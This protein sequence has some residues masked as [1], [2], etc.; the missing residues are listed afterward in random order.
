VQAEWVGLADEKAQV[1]AV[2]KALEAAAPGAGR[3]AA[4][5]IKEQE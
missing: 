2:L 4:G 3:K 5:L 1:A